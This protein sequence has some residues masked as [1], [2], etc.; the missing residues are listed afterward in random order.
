[1][2]TSIRLC[3]PPSG[4]SGVTPERKWINNTKVWL[5]VWDP[6]SGFH[7]PDRELGWC[8]FRLLSNSFRKAGT[9]GR[10]TKHTPTHKGVTSFPPA[11]GKLIPNGAAVPHLPNVPNYQIILMWLSLDTYI[12]HEIEATCLPLFGDTLTSPQCVCVN[13]RWCWL[14]NNLIMHWFVTAS[15]GKTIIININDRWRAGYWKNIPQKITFWY[16]MKC[17]N[18]VVL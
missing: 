15:Q 9:I 17:F 12:K 13:A 4:V 11:Q 18:T 7:F 10:S 2:H 1:M 14:R 5:D 8:P 6:D 16:R 3:S